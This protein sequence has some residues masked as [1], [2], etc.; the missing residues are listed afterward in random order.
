MGTTESIGGSAF[1][2]C[3]ELTQ[4]EFPGRET[5]AAAKDIEGPRERPPRLA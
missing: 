5:R 1:G 3:C 2:H 4:D